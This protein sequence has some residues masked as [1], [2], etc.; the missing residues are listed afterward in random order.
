M[1][2]QGVVGGVHSDDDDDG[3]ESN[4]FGFDDSNGD[5]R[6]LQGGDDGRW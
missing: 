5:Y 1:T 6:A 3:N 4:H 2:M